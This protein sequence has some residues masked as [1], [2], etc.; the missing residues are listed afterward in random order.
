M[1]MLM[2]ADMYLATSIPLWHRTHFITCTTAMLILSS[3]ILTTA[4]YALWLVLAPSHY[5]CYYPGAM[6]SSVPLNQPSTYAIGFPLEIPTCGAIAFS[7]AIGCRLRQLSCRRNL[8]ISFSPPAPLQIAACSRIEHDRKQGTTSHEQESCQVNDVIGIQV[9]SN[10][11]PI[12]N[13][14]KK[15]DE[16]SCRSYGSRFDSSGGQPELNPPEKQPFTRTIPISNVNPPLINHVDRGSQVHVAQRRRFKLTFLMLIRFALVNIS[17]FVV[18]AVAGFDEQSTLCYSLFL[19]CVGDA[20]LYRF[21]NPRYCE[22]RRK[23]AL[24][25]THRLLQ[26]KLCWIKDSLDHFRYSLN[27]FNKLVL[28]QNVNSNSKLP[29]LYSFSKQFASDSSKRT[30]LYIIRNI[31]VY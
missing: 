16:T 8:R 27:S 23:I 9:S 11:Q 31:L 29:Y 18:L 6:I 15:I 22:T 26:L 7:L 17:A 12:L 25:A 20:F 5:F 10:Q 30:A 14:L 21:F 4:Y 2:N 1:M 13:S 19:N 28:L 3:A 24:A